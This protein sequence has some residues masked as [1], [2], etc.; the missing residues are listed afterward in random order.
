VTD[1]ELHFLLISSRYLC[2]T[3][4]IPVLYH[5]DERLTLRCCEPVAA[6]IKETLHRKSV[7]RQ[8][9]RRASNAGSALR[10]GIA[11]V[12]EIGYAVSLLILSANGIVEGHEQRRTTI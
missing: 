6:T 4:L 5:C 9:D 1:V 12:F 11:H 3:Y 2:N 8:C 7:L 10:R